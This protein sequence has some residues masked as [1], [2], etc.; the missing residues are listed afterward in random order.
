L[1]ILD[2]HITL[3]ELNAA[4]GAYPLVSISNNAAL[5]MKADSTIKGGKRTAPGGGVA[6]TGGGQFTMSNGT[7]S[8]NTAT[9]Y[10]GG[11][12]VDGTFTKTGGIIYGSNAQEAGQ[13]NQARDDSRGHAV[14]IRGNYSY[15]KKRNTTA[16]AS[17]AMDS[18]KDGPAGGWE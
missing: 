1:L 14:V 7:I 2:Q 12:N 10:G 11:V 15:N 3:D 18:R 17:T 6:V 16:R 8:G 9:D 4:N 13:A 5:E